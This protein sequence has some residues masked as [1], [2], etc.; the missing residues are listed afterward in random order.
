M[1]NFDIVQRDNNRMIY[2]CDVKVYRD[3]VILLTNSMPVFLYSRLNYD[4]VNFR[5]WM[6]SVEEAVEGTYCKG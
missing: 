2:P 6:A 3:D 5:V 1:R 4:E